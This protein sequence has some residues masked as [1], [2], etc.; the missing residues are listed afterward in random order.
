[1]NKVVIEGLNLSH[2]R[3]IMKYFKSLGLK[4]A[5][6][7][8]FLWEKRSE[9]SF[10]FYYMDGNSQIERCYEREI[11]GLG[12]NLIKLPEEFCAPRKKKVKEENLYN[13]Y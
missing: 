8:D 12:L 6:K 9:D 5:D 4:N 2:C 1:M 7:D 10:R 11:K 3:G 13:I